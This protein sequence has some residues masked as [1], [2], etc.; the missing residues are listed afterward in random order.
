ML[1]DQMSEEWWTRNDVEGNGYGLNGISQNV[2]GG[3]E[4]THENPARIASV[5]A[6]IR[7]KCLWIQ[8]QSEDQPL[9]WDR[10]I[11]VKVFYITKCKINMKL[12]VLWFSAWRQKFPS[13]LYFSFTYNIFPSTMQ[14]I[15][16]PFPSH[17]VWLYTAI[18]RCMTKTC[19]EKERGQ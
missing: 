9:S 15:I 7:N 19:C 16:V 11:K 18:I 10:V 17:K 4:E 12:E 6:E 5:P 14:L 3:T 2:P 1:D 13:C 8:L